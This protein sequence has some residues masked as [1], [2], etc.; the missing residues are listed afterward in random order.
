MDHIRS[1]CLARSV[2]PFLRHVVTKM[3]PK[4]GADPAG[5]TKKGTIVPD[6]MALEPWSG[7]R[8]FLY[9][10]FVCKLNRCRVEVDLGL[11]LSVQK[12]PNVHLALSFLPASPLFFFLSFFVGLSWMRVSETFDRH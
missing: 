5:R 11:S 9:L 6:T 10:L 1:I 2:T 4:S 12:S 3:Y 8:H 7:D